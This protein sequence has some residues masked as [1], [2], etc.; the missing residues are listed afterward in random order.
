[1][2][3]A[4]EMLR[5]WLNGTATGGPNGD[6]RY[7]LIGAD[8]QTYLIKCPAAQALDP[9]MDPSEL[10]VFANTA[11][12]AATE[13]TQ[14]AHSASGSAT[15]ASNSASA[16]ATSAS[17]ALGYRNTASTH[18]T[19]ATT[20]A[21][22]A[23][24]S[25]TTATGAATTASTANTNAQAAKTAAESARTKAQ[26]WADKA[27]DSPVETGKFSARHWAL[28]AAASAAALGNLAWSAISGKPSV[29]AGDGL[30]GGGLLDT[31]KTISLGHPSNVTP[32]SVNEASGST[33]THNL[34]LAYAYD[35]NLPA[36]PSEYPQN[37]VT[38]T[39]VGSA[40][41]TAWPHFGVSLNLQTVSSRTAQ[42]FVG[43]NHEL[44]FQYGSS[45]WG[46]FR[47]VWH[48]SNF[49]PAS[50]QDK[51]SGTTGQY[52][53]GDGSLASFPAIPAGTVTSVTGGNGLSGTVT[54]SGSISLGTPST[55]SGSTTNSVS[56]SSH[57]HALS[58]NLSA[59]DGFAP[60]GALIDKGSLGANRNLNDIQ[61]TGLYSQN[62]TANASSG[63]N[64]PVGVAG[65][66]EVVDTGS[67]TYQRYTTYNNGDVY[68][69]TRYT[70][71][72]YPWRKQW[73]EGN[74][75]PDSKLNVSATSTSDTNNS[76]VQRTGSADIYARLF[77]S[78]YASQ[79][80]IPASASMA[81]RNNDGTDNYIRFVSDG[82]SVKNWIGLSN[83]S[84]L[85]AGQLDIQTTAGSVSI[86][87]ANS[88][89]CHMNTDRN[90]FYMNKGLQVN[91]EIAHYQ[92]PRVPKM[93]VQ[94]GDPGS[95]AS[96]GDLWIW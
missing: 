87:P 80:T 66:L 65:M 10:E 60:T 78:T 71:T 72:W 20:K 15:A 16:A 75:N 22:E 48:D 36:L 51:L 83:I 7:P 50:K 79:S 76:V 8:G 3:T 24:T 94:S 40:N 46:G 73:D 74:F 95:A 28:K 1:M 29:L 19:T 17:Q 44:Y 84:Q 33:H 52:V 39:R 92:G 88:S 55:I 82:A 27:E 49:D 59:W 81:Y 2:A 23:A 6:G 57:T 77:R 91:G 14:S 34:N 42:L 35:T 12:Q 4:S 93:F 18:A 89:Y 31:D 85:A 58:A 68:V 61:E 26:D 38:L 64:Y 21:G 45:S 25:A 96:T 62:L 54:S 43:G 67:M 70:T 47:K 41:G 30:T 69:R 86:G 5:D 90:N 13:A 32:F 56:S 53:R 11:M 63:T 9:S 37:S